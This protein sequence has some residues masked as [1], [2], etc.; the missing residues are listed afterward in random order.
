MVP[1]CSS[2][3]DQLSSTQTTDITNVVSDFTVAQV[4]VI[5]FATNTAFRHGGAA[6]T[7][8]AEGAIGNIA[9]AVG[10]QVFADNMTVAAA[11]GPTEAEMAT[12]FGTNEVFF[13]GGANDAVYVIVDN[14][15]D[16]WI[17]SL[18]SGVAGKVFTAADDDGVVVARLVGLA[19][20]TTLSA[21]NFADF[22]A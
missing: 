6:L 5:D 15:T 20:A 21:A 4:D 17:L 19:D 9:T 22:T 18:Q 8:Y 2:L 12:Y 11:T 3:L 14:G 16:S 7:G 1:T 10:M 13:D